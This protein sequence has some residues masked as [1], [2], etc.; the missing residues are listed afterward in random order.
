VDGEALRR[1]VLE[2]VHEFGGRQGSALQSASILQES[3]RR[4]DVRGIEDERALLV[5]FGDLFR[6][7]YLA[8]GHNLSNPGPPFCHI[9]DTGRVALAPLAVIRAI[10]T[11]IWPIST[12]AASST[13]YPSRIF[14][15]RSLPMQQAATWLPR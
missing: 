1:T 12:A 15:K 8:W 6:I 7:G 5:F 4:L 11:D 14:A 3:A 10:P 9:T 13:P 2:V